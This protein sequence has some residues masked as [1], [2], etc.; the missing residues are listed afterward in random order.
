MDGKSSILIITLHDL[1]YV[2]SRKKLGNAGG[3]YKE[4]DF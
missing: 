3:K 2:A 1:T 4:Q